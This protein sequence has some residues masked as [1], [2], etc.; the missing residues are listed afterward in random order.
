MIFFIFLLL[1]SFLLLLY[2]TGVRPRKVVVLMRR[3]LVRDCG[4][5]ASNPAGRSG[6][7]LI[8]GTRCRLAR[9]PA[10]QRPRAPVTT[11]GSHCTE[12]ERFTPNQ[13]PSASIP[14]NTPRWW[15]PSPGRGAVGGWLCECVCVCV[16]VFRECVD[17]PHALDA[18]W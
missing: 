7:S 9:S 6:G 3:P 13:S 17:H 12:A 5:C 8:F 16:C 11:R 4:S 10:P 14:K 2:Y 1:L 15:H 18:A